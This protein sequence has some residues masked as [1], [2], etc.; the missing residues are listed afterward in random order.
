VRRGASWRAPGE[1]PRTRLGGA[2]TDTG[3]DYESLPKLRESFDV[4]VWSGD[5]NY[6]L[7][8]DREAADA[9][10][11]AGDVPGLLEADQL[12]KQ[13]AAQAAFSGYSEAA[14]SFKPTYKFDAATPEAP[15]PARGAAREAWLGGPRDA[16]RGATP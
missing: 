13:M 12:A 7:D 6:R 8:L 4:V 2:P 16:R 11:A 5:L 10:V 15:E 1:L 3:D 9:L 14:I